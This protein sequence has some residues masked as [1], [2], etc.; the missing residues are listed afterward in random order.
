MIVAGIDITRKYHIEEIL[1]MY[2]R[3]LLKPIALNGYGVR[4]DADGMVGFVPWNETSM[5]RQETGTQVQA[6]ISGELSQMSEAVERDHPIVR[7]S[8]QAKQAR[9]AK[10]LK[11]LPETVV[12]EVAGELWKQGT[13]VTGELVQAVASTF[14]E[15]A[16]KTNNEADSHRVTRLH[17]T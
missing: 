12:Q 14:L 15:K 17:K 16:E 3:G 9:V 6:N 5:F 2:H 11:G 8:P 7:T 10:R 4:A 1:A 13:P